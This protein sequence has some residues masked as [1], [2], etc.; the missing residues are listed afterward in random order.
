MN[1]GLP[2]APRHPARR[3]DPGCP[4]PE[5]P[6]GASLGRGLVRVLAG[7][8]KAEFAGKGCWDGLAE[9]HTPLASPPQPAC[10]FPCSC[11]NGVHGFASRGRTAVVPSSSVEL[12]RAAGSSQTRRPSASVPLPLLALEPGHP[13]PVLCRVHPAR[14]PI[15]PPI[16][17][18]ARPSIHPFSH[19][20]G[21]FFVPKTGLGSSDKARQTPKTIF[22]LKLLSRFG[23]QPLPPGSPPGCS[24]PALT[25]LPRGL[26]MLG[27]PLLWRFA[28]GAESCPPGTFWIVMPWDGVLLASR[29]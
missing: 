29:G 28:A 20:V 10:S 11:G 5:S 6:R 26:S 15:H 17:P 3:P 7:K 19:S 25:T 2:D 8:A 23:R 12:D 9:V 4:S 14:S 18:S 1:P 21:I 24:R 27:T 22:F 16:H 13:S